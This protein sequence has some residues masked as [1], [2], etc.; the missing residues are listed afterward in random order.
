MEENRL[1]KFEIKNNHYSFV[2]DPNCGRITS[3]RSTQGELLSDRQ[4]DVFCIAFRTPEGEAVK[5]ATSDCKLDGIMT[6]PDHYVLIYECE[7]PSVKVTFYIHSDDTPLLKFGLH[8]ECDLQLEWVEFPCVTV[9]DTFADHGGNSK[10]LWPYNEGAIITDIT[11][12]ENSPFPYRE[13]QYPSFGSDAMCPGMLS[14]PMMAV[15][16][17]NGGLYLGA[18][19]TNQ[20]TKSVDFYRTEDGVRLQ[21]R[22]YPGITGGIYESTY[23]TVLGVFDGDWQDAAEIYRNWFEQNQPSSLKEIGENPVLPDW[24]G[25]SPVVVT[26]CVRGHHDTDIMDPSK[27]FPY[28][29][30]LP[31]IRDLSEKL[32]SKIL[33]ILMHWEGTAPW[34][35]P[36]VWPPYGGKEALEEYINALHAE[37]HL[38][39]VYCSGLGWTKQSK[40]VDYNGDAQYNRQNLEEIM[41]ADPSG[42]VQLSA[43]CPAQRTGYDLCPSQQ[44]TKDM[45]THEVQQ[46]AASGIDYIQLMDQNHGGTPYFC[47]SKQHGHPPVPGTWASH[48]LIDMMQNIKASIDNKQLLFGCESA[49]AEVFIPE[50]LLSDNRFELNFLIGHPVPLY[51]YLYHPYLNNFMGNQVCGE[52]AM[53]ECVTKENL[54]YRQA[55]SFAAG[56]FLT[57]VIN[58]EG[59]VQWAWG[60]RDF[61]PEYMPDHDATVDFVGKLN[62]WRK[63]DAAKYLH[64]GKMVK[65]LDISTD[66]TFELSTF[67]GIK[68]IPPVITACYEAK[69]G[70]KGQFVV[71]FTQEPVHCTIPENA[72]LQ[73]FRTPDLQDPQTLADNTFTVEPLSAVL[74]K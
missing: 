34:A 27:L 29:N 47:Y 52:G 1:H 4:A 9:P 55:Y 71:N 68:T 16:S 32:D 63:G 48:E 13:P 66:R 5:V 74:L 7:E 43:I 72:K 59:K 38:L 50:M 12:R 37:G 20:N 35:P 44:K 61:S 49:A 15:M 69:D 14:T 54:W 25:E 26:Y 45:I 22:V 23:D 17:D 57:L 64:T 21:M 42:K 6:L 30:G 11:G 24:Y 40:L 18:H 2:Y 33:V 8:L 56:D 19:D 53:K 60:Q 41:C 73:M 36:V 62:A 58:D 3:F 28:A 39:G 46:M 67:S 51:S 31:I 10:I 65:P 70:S